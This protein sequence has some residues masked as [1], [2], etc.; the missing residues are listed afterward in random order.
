MEDQ[1]EMTVSEA[2]RMLLNFFLI[3]TIILSVLAAIFFFGVTAMVA[4]PP[5][6]RAGAQWAGDGPSYGMIAAAI[7]FTSELVRRLFVR[8]PRISR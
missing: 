1:T 3:L 8:K 2:L 5:D 4:P 7:A 6:Q